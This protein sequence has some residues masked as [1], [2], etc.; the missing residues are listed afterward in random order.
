MFLGFLLVYMGDYVYRRA[1]LLLLLR[2]EIGEAYPKPS[3]Q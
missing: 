1:S 2:W 3:Q